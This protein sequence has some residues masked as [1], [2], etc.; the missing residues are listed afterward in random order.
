MSTEQMI[1][2]MQAYMDGK[3]I[4]FSDDG[5][6]WHEED[7]EDMPMW[8]WVH[9]IYRKKPE[10]TIRPYTYREATEYIGEIAQKIIKDGTLCVKQVRLITSVNLNGDEVQINGLTAKEFSEKYRWLDGSPCG[11]EVVE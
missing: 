3:A 2:V 1:K 10:P 6:N 11:V 4:Q 8:D 9:Y 7:F 5:E